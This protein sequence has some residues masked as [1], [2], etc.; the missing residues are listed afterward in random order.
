MERDRHMRR[1]ARTENRRSA[2]WSHLKAGFLLLLAWM[3]LVV[4]PEPS[5]AQA[6]ASAPPALGALSPS[7]TSGPYLSGQFVAVS[8]APNMVLKPGAHLTIEECSAASVNKTTR[9]Y[10]CDTR[11]KQKH[12]FV[13]NSDGSANYQAYPIYALPDV[14]TLRESH[15]HRPVCNLQ[16]ACVLLI[17]WDIDDAGHGVWTRPFFASPTAG[18]TGTGPGTGTPEVPYVLAL[19]VIALG[20]FGGSV[21][22]RRRRSVTRQAV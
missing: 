1:Q 21:L 13:A 9:H 14:F 2:W 11:T 10:D 7:P 5:T 19:P 16:H 3:F 20:I 8:V 15:H 18:D 4:G 12:S 22:L 17:G 6:G